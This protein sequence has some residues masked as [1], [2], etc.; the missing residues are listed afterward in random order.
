[1]GFSDFFFFNCAFPF[2]HSFAS[3]GRGPK[4]GA[5]QPREEASVRGDGNQDQV[6]GRDRQLE[7]DGP[8]LLRSPGVSHSLPTPPDTAV[9]R[10]KNAFTKKTAFGALSGRPVRQGITPTGKACAGEEQSLATL[11]HCTHFPGGRMQVLL[12]PTTAG[13]KRKEG[14]NSL[15]SHARQ[16]C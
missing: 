1:M 11:P 16:R 5:K 2:R 8:L 4:R 10:R 14:S 12:P 13:S 3:L 9:W 7:R 6:G 15:S